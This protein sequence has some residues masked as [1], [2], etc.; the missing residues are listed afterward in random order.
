[1][2][3]CVSDESNNFLFSFYFFKYKKAN[4]NY[5]NNP[6]GN[7][8]NTEITKFRRHIQYQILCTVFKTSNNINVL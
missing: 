8:N 3:K 2:R 4:L 7:N 1:M 6:K 5:F